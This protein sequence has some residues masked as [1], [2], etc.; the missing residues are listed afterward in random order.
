MN[1][2]HKFGVRTKHRKA[3]LGPF[4]PRIMVRVSDPLLE[5]SPYPHYWILVLIWTDKTRSLYET[6]KDLFGIISYPRIRVRVSDPLLEKSPNSLNLILVL[7]WTYEI[8]L[9]FVR[10]SESPVWVPSYPRIRV[11]V[12][13]PL[14]EKSPNSQNWILVLIWTDKTNW[15]FV[16]NSERPVWDTFL[17]P[18]ILITEF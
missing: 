8:N 14:L 7:I 18:L 13:D 17:P 4:L 3:C 12:S 6:R 15:E 10:N 5:K 16:R 9:E 2:R 11:R 1:L